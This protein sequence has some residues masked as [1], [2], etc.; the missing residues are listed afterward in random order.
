[1]ANKGSKYLRI[2]NR[3]KG[4]VETFS[5]DATVFLANRGLTVAD[6]AVSVVSGNAVS[7]SAQ[8]R[9][10][11]LL[12]FQI[13]FNQVGES[14]VKVTTTVSGNDENAISLWLFRTLDD[15]SNAFFRDYV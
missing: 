13:S 7:I 3:V 6:M 10:G 11:D 15:G 14:V 5:E 8:S 2:E 12:S 4:R 9:T 1:M